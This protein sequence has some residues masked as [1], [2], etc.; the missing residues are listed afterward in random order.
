M[1]STSSAARSSRWPRSSVKMPLPGAG[2]GS[3]VPDLFHDGAGQLV[4]V[5]VRRDP[6]VDYVDEHRMDA[7]L[8]DGRG[9][10][11]HSL[12]PGR[13]GGRRQREVVVAVEQGE[14]GV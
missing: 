10:V 2:C 14:V 13:L 6:W 4:R 12:D 7:A 8:V 11:D 5:M 3:G 9:I 1:S